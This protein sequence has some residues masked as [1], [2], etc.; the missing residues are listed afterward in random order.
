MLLAIIGEV[1]EPVTSPSSWRGLRAMDDTSLTIA[2]IT[3]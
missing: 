2:I 3:L 1:R